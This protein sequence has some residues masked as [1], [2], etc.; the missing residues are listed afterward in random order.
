M[1][2]AATLNNTSD[3]IVSRES[4]EFDGRRAYSVH[5]RKSG[6]L[7]GHVART[8]NPEYRGAW[9]YL[10]LLDR[11]DV[12]GAWTMSGWTRAEAVDRLMSADNPTGLYRSELS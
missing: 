2:A 4:F 11:R 3:V 5:D 6:R 7:V 8:R 12:S 10:G 9:V 1:G